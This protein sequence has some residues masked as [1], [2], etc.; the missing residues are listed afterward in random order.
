MK[1]KF[2][3][4]RKTKKVL[5]KLILENLDPNWKPKDCKITSITKHYRYSEKR[6]THKGISVTGYTL[7]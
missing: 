3:I 5:K 7:G 2:R 6:P 4:P 1:T